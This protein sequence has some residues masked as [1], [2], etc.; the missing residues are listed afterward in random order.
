MSLQNTQQ[1][2][3]SLIL[4]SLSVIAVRT[5]E[6]HSASGKQAVNGPLAK[7][8]AR[9]PLAEGPCA[10]CVKNLTTRQRSYVSCTKR[11]TQSLGSNRRPGGA[12]GTNL[13]RSERFATTLLSVIIATNGFPPPVQPRPM[14]RS[15]SILTCRWQAETHTGAPAFLL[16][17][18]AAMLPLAAEGRTY[19]TS[20]QKLHYSTAQDAKC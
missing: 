7:S 5:T 18:K 9:R 4:G 16:S 8:E 13:G 12:A 15:S 3:T 17:P 6:F 10:L 19:S 14:T 11:T 1:G 20:P 2:Q